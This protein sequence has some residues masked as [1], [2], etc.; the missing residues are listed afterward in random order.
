V[1]RVRS[2]GRCAI[3]TRD[4]AAG[5][6]VLLE[7]AIAFAPRD[8]FAHAVCHHC[9]ADLPTHRVGASAFCSAACSTAVV[10][11]CGL[12]PQLLRR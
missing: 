1:W 4:I 10:R 11:A 6:L 2:R 7:R 5:E 3:A 8:C 9:L 12:Q